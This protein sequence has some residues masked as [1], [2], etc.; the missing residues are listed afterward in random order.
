MNGMVKETFDYLGQFA[1]YAGVGMV[2]A[3]ADIGALYLLTEYGG[4][5]YLLS[6]VLSFG[7]GVFL[8]YA[9]SIRFVF[10]KRKMESRKKEFAVFFLIGI[11]GLLLNI[12]LIWF[13]TE[14]L[15]IYYIYSKYIATAIGFF[16]NFNARKFIL[17]N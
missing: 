1:K 11:L 12:A 9:L 10:D 4:L 7:L 15:E 13:F 2:A 3:I 17:F 8:N 14:R 16:F 6:A 5:Y